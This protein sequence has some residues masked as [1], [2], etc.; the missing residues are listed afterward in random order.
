MQQRL[1]RHRV[2]AGVLA[3]AGA[4]TP[5]TAQGTP[6]REPSGPPGA[7]RERQARPISV[8]ESYVG[9]RPEDP[10]AIDQDPNP[11]APS[12]YRNTAPAGLAVGAAGLAAVGMGR[13]RGGARTRRSSAPVLAIGRCG[14]FVGWA[15]EL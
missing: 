8:L 12:L 4:V 1:I 14:G 13:W 11:D 3:L 7:T 2:G 15:G 10:G 6:S 9:Q 5:V